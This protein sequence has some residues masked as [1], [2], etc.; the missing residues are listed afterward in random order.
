MPVESSVVKESQLYF[1]HLSPTDRRMKHDSSGKVMAKLIAAAALL[2][3]SV[4]GM[5]FYFSSSTI[6]S[7]LTENQELNKAIENLTAEEQIGYATLQSQW[8]DENG[9]LQSTIRFVQTAAGKP[10]E[11]VSEQEFIINGDIIH[12][13]ALIVKFTDEYIKDGKGRSLYLWRRVYGEANSPSSGELIEIPGDAP[14][15]YHSV[16]KSLRMKDSDIFW[17]AIW[18]LANNPE[19]LSQ[20]GI[21]AVFGNAIYSR[22]LTGQITLFKISPTGQIYPEILDTY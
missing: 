20:Y 7:L 15:R 12:F 17:E 3:A 10:K 6:H 11:I 22:M 14:E 9:E 13:D 1:E 2:T 16:T 8:R 18:D 5:S 21:K 19:Q 4:L